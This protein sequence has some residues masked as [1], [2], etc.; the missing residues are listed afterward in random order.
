MRKVNV[1]EP[2]TIEDADSNSIQKERT[3]RVGQINDP[4]VEETPP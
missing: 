2:N 1:T 4:E 3:P